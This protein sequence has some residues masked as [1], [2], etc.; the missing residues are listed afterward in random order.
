MIHLTD[1]WS[2]SGARGT[3]LIFHSSSPSGLQMLEALGERTSRMV[4]RGLTKAAR[5]Q[6]RSGVVDRVDIGS[7]TAE[8]PV[9][10]RRGR[11]SEIGSMSSS[12]SIE[13][14]DLG[15]RG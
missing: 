13:N 5:V 14:R 11:S 8:N 3:D 9:I 6:A 7:S 12:V 2:L 1:I 15:I 10:F 4:V